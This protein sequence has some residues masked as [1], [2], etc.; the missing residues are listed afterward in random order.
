MGE[1]IWY[2][3]RFIIQTRLKENKNEKEKILN[4]SICAYIYIL[5]SLI[6]IFKKLNTKNVIKYLTKLRK[7]NFLNQ[8]FVLRDFAHAQRFRPYSQ[9]IYLISMETHIHAHT[10]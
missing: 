2:T 3:V 9:N 7:I 1:R 5:L 4:F 10:C 8:I 6:N